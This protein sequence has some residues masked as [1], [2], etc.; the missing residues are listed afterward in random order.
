MADG[1][2]I[3]VKAG[4]AELALGSEAPGILDRL[5]PWRAA[6][7]RATAAVTS[8]IVRKLESNEPFSPADVQFAK[9]VFDEPAAKWFR[10]QEIA[11]RA[12]AALEAQPTRLELP[13][14]PSASTDSTASGGTAEDWLTR[15]WDDAGLVSDGV[16]QEIYGRILAGE[17]QRPGTCSMRTL[18]V[19]RYLDRATADEFAKVLPC[20][21]GE[22][23][24][25]RGDALLE[26]FGIPFNLL[27]SL[28]DAGLLDTASVQMKWSMPVF[29]SS[30]TRVLRLDSPGRNI[31][32]YT[33]RAPGKELAHVAEVA[34][35]RAYFDEL[36]R[37]VVSQGFNVTWAELPHLR[38]RGQETDLTW[39]PPP[40][41][42]VT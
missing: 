40:P 8:A 14:G 7:G 13:P 26:R 27:L 31:P 6:R 22:S 29:L 42:T 10:Q 39:L 9:A 30:G 5:M 15:F 32:I 18:R 21:V 25:P 38:W 3:K 17:A 20:V 23:W 2:G 34:F 16:L 19:L 41:E 28:S 33:L 12:R 24:L 37:W 11:Q 36:L 35:S 4:P 1:D